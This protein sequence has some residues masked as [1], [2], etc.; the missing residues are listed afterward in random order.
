[1]ESLNKK[2]WLLCSLIGFAFIFAFEYVVHG[3]CLKDMYD[4]SPELWRS[5]ESMVG[6]F[7]FMV[8]MQV[9][10]VAVT[11]YIFA[12]NYEGKGMGE[13]L[14]FGVPFGLLIA[15]FYTAPFAWLPI[16]PLLAVYWALSGL[17]EGVVLGLIF[18]VLYKAK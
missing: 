7:P 16:S 10:F 13:G 18:S 5:P 12:Q 4:V 6:Y 8:L 1:M 3:V 9:L 17:I 15:I 11:A 2:Q 14:R